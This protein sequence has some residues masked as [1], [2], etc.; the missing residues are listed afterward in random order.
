MKLESWT[1]A[2]GLELERGAL[3]IVKSKRNILVVAGPG[4]G[5]TELLAQ[6]ACYLLQTG[7]CKDPK[8]ILAISFK[9][10]AAKNLKDRVNQ[11]VGDY[12]ANRFDSWTFDAFSKGLLDH[13]LKGLPQEW[14]PSRDYIIDNSKGFRDF[15]TYHGYNDK[16]AENI[17]HNISNNQLKPGASP[18]EHWRYLLTG[19]SQKRS[20]LSFGMISRLAEFII[21]LNPLI[22]RSLCLT[23]SHIFIDEFQD[24]TTIQ[25]DLLKTCFGDSTIPITAVGDQKQRIMLWAGARRSIFQDFKRDFSADLERLLMNYRS[26]PRLIELQK[27]MYSSL[28]EDAL[29]IKYAKQWAPDDGVVTLYEF[30]YSSQEAS[31]ISRDIQ[32]KMYNGA[33]PREICILAKQKIDQYAMELSKE[34]E[35]LGIKSRID[36]DYQKL[37]SEPLVDLFLSLITLLF[38]RDE[39]S[40]VT[41]NSYW[42]SIVSY[43]S[44]ERDME[45]KQSQFFRDKQGLTLSLN[46]C[47]SCI[48]FIRYLQIDCLD[49]FDK[50]KIQALYSPY[51]QDRVLNELITSFATSLWALYEKNGG[52]WYEAVKEFYGNDSIP[53]MTIHKSKGLEYSIVYFLGL[54]DSA[55]WNFRNQPEEDRSAFFVALSRAKREVIFTFCKNRELFRYPI[56][57]RQ[58]I[59]E[60]YDLLRSADFVEIVQF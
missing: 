11:R 7:L 47:N 53:I 26:A 34:L 39:Q 2:D 16:Q 54:E 56:Q 55:F 22:K 38:V 25:Y 10:D 57:K 27:R 59:N 31:V 1:P 37:L 48:E 36:D 30:S 3:K 23:Y 24:T 58:S 19:D 50:S 52:E 17:L 46:A 45:E 9:R 28:N 33:K 43:S 5:K 13:F 6:K 41:I 49:V 14:Q 44:I 18:T 42:E 40:W 60:F 15:L 21:L 4:A 32:D 8:K 20:M 12:N 51:K 35:S 29:E